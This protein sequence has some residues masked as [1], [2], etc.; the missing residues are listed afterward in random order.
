MKLKNISKKIVDL[1]FGI[2]MGIILSLGACDGSSPGARMFSGKGKGQSIYAHGQA[3]HNVQELRSFPGP[4]GQFA[5]QF[6]DKG[7]PVW[8]FAAGCIV[9]GAVGGTDMGA[10]TRSAE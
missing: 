10:T 7:E 4:D 2:V 9:G 6:A 8:C 5:I 1:Y 3:F